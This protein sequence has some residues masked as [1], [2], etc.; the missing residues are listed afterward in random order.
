MRG[1][2]EDRALTWAVEAGVL[3]RAKRTGWW[4]SGVKDPESLAEHS[5]RMSLLAAYIAAEEGGDPS[6]AGML[7][8]IHDLPEARIGDVHAAGKRYMAG[9]EAGERMARKEQNAVL[10]EGAFRSL[11]EELAR[12]W[13]ACR[14]KEAR[15]AK[16]ADYLECAL[17]A[18]EYLWQR[19]AVCREWVDSNIRRLKTPTGK[20]LGSRLRRLFLRGD[21][22]EFQAWW[23][24]FYVR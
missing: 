9:L 4:C 10:P 1:G 17:Q 23:R 3:K 16:D 13:T 8:L 15:A 7:G 12:E 21:W 14:T 5:F 2:R 24:P 6:R 18:V 20:R 11:S 19:K 22:D